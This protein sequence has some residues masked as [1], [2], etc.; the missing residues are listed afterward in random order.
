MKYSAIDFGPNESVYI[1]YAY[2][3]LDANIFIG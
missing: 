3:K 1:L 2:N